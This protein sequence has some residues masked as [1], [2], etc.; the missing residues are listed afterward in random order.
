MKLIRGEAFTDSLI[1]TMKL[2]RMARIA[3][4]GIYLS[5]QVLKTDL[6]FILE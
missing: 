2:D 4:R 6:C 5:G 1:V 3:G